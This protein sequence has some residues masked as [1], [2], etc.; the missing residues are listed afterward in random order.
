VVVSIVNTPGAQA[1]PG[2]IINDA[3]VRWAMQQP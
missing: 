3:V 2:V 1:G